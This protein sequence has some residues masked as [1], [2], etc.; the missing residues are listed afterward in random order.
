MQVF[1]EVLV[2]SHGACS[3]VWFLDVL[4]LRDSSTTSTK[5]DHASTRSPEIFIQVTLCTGGAVKVS[6]SLLVPAGCGDLP[7]LD[8]VLQF[9]D[10][11]VCY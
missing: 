7:G 3:V 1:L 11:K 6:D 2:T 9:C 10:S 8:G 5:H 4:G